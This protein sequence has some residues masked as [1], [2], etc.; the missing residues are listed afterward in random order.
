VRAQTPAQDHAGR[1]F[2]ADIH[3]PLALFAQG[4]AGRYLH[5]MH[6][7]AHA[8]DRRTSPAPQ[9][10]D[11]DSIELPASIADFETSI[12]N[13]GAYRISVLRQIGY[14]EGGMAEFNLDCARESMAIPTVEWRGAPE[15]SDLDRFFALWSR[16]ALLRRVFLAL[17]LLRVDCRIRRSYPGARRDLERVL[18]KALAARTPDDSHALLEALI[19]YCLGAHPLDLVR[20]S[21][22]GQLDDILAVAEPLQSS[23]ADVYST[24]RAAVSI[25]AAL[26]VSFSAASLGDIEAGAQL[27]PLAASSDDMS[28]SDD[29]DM[30][31]LN[32]PGEFIPKVHLGRRRA[33]QA[34]NLPTPV[35]TVVTSASPDRAQAEDATM[36]PAGSARASAIAVKTSMSNSVRSYLYDEWDYHGQ[37][38]LRGWCRLYEQKLRGDWFGFIDDV[39][40]RYAVL[41]H[42]VRRQFGLVRPELWHRVRRTSDGDELELDSVIEAV[43]DR[44]TSGAGDSKLYIRRDR[45]LRDVATA[46]LLDMSASTGFPLPDTRQAASSFENSPYLHGGLDELPQPVQTPK[47]RVIDV[48]KDALALMCEALE[49][50]GDSSAIYGFSGEG[51]DRV[52]FHIAKDFADRL[53][54]Q[55]WA[56]LA[57]ME[58]LRS[59]RM[60]AAIRHAIVKLARQPARMK[61]LIIVSDG[62]P[63]DTDYGPDRKDDHYGIADTACALREAQRAGI[64]AFCV[65]IDPAGNDYLRR[66]CAESRYM[67]I[68]DVMS[69][70]RELTKIYRTLTVR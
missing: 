4:I 62:Y 23:N 3:R 57:A 69:L 67:V 33:G 26:D 37:M 31:G 10:E 42:Q 51:H 36:K 40:R 34:G 65:T 2:L 25:C 29:L 15:I 38:Y 61:V 56:A 52:E 46:F 9:S 21:D 32:F 17:E 11:G 60:G 28:Q 54:S 39:H 70:P 44:R 41:A 59:T 22:S 49:G 43:I 8:G 63:Q 64:V 27:V 30:M 35:F 16:P 12:H 66:M 45:A 5:L 7:D 18:A 55:T 19:R 47:R 24:A 6:A 68:D 14:L 20:H 13:L 1:V 50:L 58:P 53:S 48:A